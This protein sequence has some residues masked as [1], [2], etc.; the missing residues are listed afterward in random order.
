SRSTCAALSAKADFSAVTFWETSLQ[1]VHRA[2][3]DATA[4]LVTHV[5]RR[6]SDFA[7]DLGPSVATHASQR[8]CGL[9]RPHVTFS[10]APALPA[11]AGAG[12]GVEK[13]LECSYMT[14]R[15][16]RDRFKPEEIKAWKT[17]SSTLRWS[18]TACPR[19]AKSQS[20][21]PRDCS[22]SATSRWLTR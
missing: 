8:Q 10:R 12:A 3:S 15:N 6:F 21:L 9:R 2:I 13:P 4:I 11:L 19:R 1:P 20:F 5:P 7:R 16:G 17:S 22:T 18:I 14:S